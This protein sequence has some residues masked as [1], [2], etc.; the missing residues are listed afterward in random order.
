MKRFIRWFLIIFALLITTTSISCGVRER[1]SYHLEYGE[2]NNVVSFGDE[3][4]LTGL[5]I[6]K[7]Q[8]S[9]YEDIAVTS[10]M[11]T[12]CDSTLS[13]G[14][15]TLTI[16][17]DT[18]SVDVNFTVKYQINFVIGDKTSTQY[19]LSTAEIVVPTNTYL[20]GYE[21]IGWDP[22]I[23]SVINSNMTF[24][25]KYT[26]VPTNV[27]NVGSYVATYSDTF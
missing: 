9:T 17:Y 1:V 16:G 22:V 13:V 2:F 24:V 14:S 5:T 23:P 21:F 10:Q 26:D 3:V 15:K 11:V 20:K 4:D 18:Y 25:A 12:R 7:T 8:G 27:P 19:V 6:R